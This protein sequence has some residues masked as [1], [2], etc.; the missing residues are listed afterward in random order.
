MDAIAPTL[1]RI[2]HAW[3]HEAPE[4]SQTVNRVAYRV[5]TPFEAMEKSGRID[6]EHL[7]AGAKLTMHYRGAEGVKVGNGEGSG[8]HPDTE[9]PQIYHG[10]MV[11]RAWKE[12]TADERRALEA[13]IEETATVED[14]GRRCTH[15]KDRRGAEIAGRML[16]RGGLERLALH[17][18]FRQRSDP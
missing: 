7:K 1:E 2:R 12:I 16:V 5:L 9:Y 14:I 17:W 10:Q 8:E 6:Y 15:I 13:L 4:R 11:A 3:G 18:G